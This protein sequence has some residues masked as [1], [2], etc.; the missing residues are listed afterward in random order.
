MG[1][2]EKRCRG[3]LLERSCGVC[4]DSAIQELL[5]RVERLEAAIAKILEEQ[6]PTLPIRAEDGEVILVFPTQG[7]HGSEWRLRRRQLD[8]WQRLFPGLDVMTE[9]RHALAWVSAQPAHRKT[10][11]GMPKFLVSWFT[12]SVDRR[13]NN[14]QPLL[15][16]GKSKLT[17][18]LEKASD[19]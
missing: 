12:R 4:E 1:M 3:S 2:R 5:R 16:D 15:G 8:E 9:C 13:G 6:A 7:A 18:A 17:H 11:K 19:W 14:R 10:V